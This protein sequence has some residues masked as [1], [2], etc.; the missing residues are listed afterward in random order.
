[1]RAPRIPGGPRPPKHNQQNRQTRE[2]RSR[3]RLLDKGKQNYFKY[4]LEDILGRS[5]TPAEM[6][7]SIIQTLWSKGTR[8][9]VDAAREFLKEKHDEGSVDDETRRFIDKA[10]ERYS[11]TR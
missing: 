3:S 11:T 10:I 2:S 6:H 8:D 5:T 9:G 1:M 4:D 7:G